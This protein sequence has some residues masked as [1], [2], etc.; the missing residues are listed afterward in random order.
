[1]HNTDNTNRYLV[2]S[3]LHLTDIEDHADGWKAYKSSRYMIDDAFAALLRNFAQ[4]GENG[5]LTLVLNGDIFDFDLVTAVPERPEWPVSRAE[6]RRGLCATGDKSA[7]KLRQIL[8]DH[9]VFVQALSE[10][11]GQGNRLVYIMGNH[12]REMHFPQVRDTFLLSLQQDGKKSIQDR[13]RFEPWFF[14]EP[15]RLY[16]EHGQQYDYYSTFKYLLCP[17]IKCRHQ[18]VLSLPMGNLS[19]RYLM[20]RMGFFNPH[21][22][23]FILNAFQYFTHW[24]RHYAFSRRS[25]LMN[26]FFGSLVTMRKLWKYR[27]K[28]QRHPPDCTAALQKQVERSG[29]DEDTLKRIAAMEKRPIT[30]MFFR[31]M[32]ELWIDRVLIALFLTGV[33][34]ALA[35]V[36]IPLWIKLMVPLSAFPLLYFI[37]EKAV[38]GVDVFTVDQEIPKYAGRIARLLPVRLVVFGHTHK[39]RIL[40]LDNGVTFV[41]TGTWAPIYDRSGNHVRGYH[42]YLAVSFSDSGHTVD[43]GCWDT[44][45][46]RVIK[47][48]Q[49]ED[50]QACQVIRRQVFIREQAV[51]PE[52]EVD[53][54]DVEA[55]HFLAMVGNTPVGTAR[56][57][58]VNRDTCK[59]ERVAV[60]RHM[61]GLG[62]G[63]ALMQAIEDH[64]RTSGCTQVLLHAQ[65]RVREFYEK[66][67]YEPF[68]DVFLDARIEH[69]AMKKS[70][71]NR[72]S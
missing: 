59:A 50:I 57:R 65:I 48:K 72:P 35:L 2:V 32:R 71:V 70:M 33:T 52:E 13:V 40:P 10:F 41:D 37:Y 25:L 67:G 21:A 11:V 36:P 51:K 14:Y 20:T 45:Q 22:T 5:D 31:V 60:L 6:R 28:M 69:V 17:T 18:D 55:T 46:P 47:V 63:R 38:Q 43:F 42:N 30:D 62:V 3:D 9:P 58:R 26:W 53:G 68:G 4:Q 1:M 12:D 34:V 61:R 66:L 8:Q 23:D 19:N 39:P 29:V 15:G 44:R 56:V 54:L 24:W 7:W 27:Y 16:V 49:S 64:A